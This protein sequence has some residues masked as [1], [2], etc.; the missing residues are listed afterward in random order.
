MY[1]HMEG[2]CS[3]IFKSASTD[4]MG[5]ITPHNLVLHGK[6]FTVLKGGLQHCA[7]ISYG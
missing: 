6:A 7:Y 4:L 3:H 1:S 5:K 2:Y